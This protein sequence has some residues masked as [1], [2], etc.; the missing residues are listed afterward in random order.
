MDSAVEV[1]Q[2]LE[3]AAEF[4]RKVAKT[5]KSEN[6]KPA[7]D[8]IANLENVVGTRKVRH[9]RGIWCLNVERCPYRKMNQYVFIALHQHFSPSKTSFEDD[10]LTENEIDYFNSLGIETPSATDLSNYERDDPG[11]G[12]VDLIYLSQC[13]RILVNNLLWSLWTPERLKNLILIGNFEKWKYCDGIPMHSL[14]YR[15]TSL[16]NELFKYGDWILRYDIEVCA[17]EYSGEGPLPLANRPDYKDYML[18][19]VIYSKLSSVEKKK[20]MKTVSTLADINRNVAMFKEL[21]RNGNLRSHLDDFDAHLRGRKIARISVTAVGHIG[22]RYDLLDSSRH[23]TKELAWIATL[24]QHYNIKHIS[25]RDP[26]LSN[27]EL[28]YLNASGI[29]TPKCGYLDEPEEG[30]Q[31]GEVAIIWMLHGWKDMYNNVLWANRG[32]M[33]KIVLVGNDYPSLTKWNL[34]NMTKKQ[35]ILPALGTASATMVLTTMAGVGSIAKVLSVGASV[36][37]ALY[38][39]ENFLYKEFVKLKEYAALK[40]FI[41]KALRTKFHYKIDQER[42]GDCTCIMSYPEKELQGIGDKKP[43]YVRNYTFYSFDQNGR[44]TRNPMW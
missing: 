21:I 43:V 29:E 16:I 19:P 36:L 23:G 39:T 30:L 18:P 15:E 24:K 8:V 10:C 40:A 14:C 9:L 1:K 44:A 25:V 37:G 17:C 42:Q 5:P 34:C 12:E 13:S 3:D 35:A 31:D 32:Q 22:Y 27:F 38:V 4:F 26:C 41:R 11:S 6:P 33:D 2:S 7:E 20:Y 28:Y